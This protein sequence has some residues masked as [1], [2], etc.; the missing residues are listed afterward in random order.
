[1]IPSP[2]LAPPDAAPLS[3]VQPGFGSVHTFPATPNLLPFPSLAR[4]FL[5]FFSS[6][7]VNPQLSKLNL[8]PFDRSHVPSPG[9]SQQSPLPIHT[10]NPYL[11][12]IKQSPLPSSSSSTSSSSGG[13]GVDAT[14]GGQTVPNPRMNYASVQRLPSFS[15][16]GPSAV[17]QASPIQ[18]RPPFPSLVCSTSTRAVRY[19]PDCLHMLELLNHTSSDPL[20]LAGHR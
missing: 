3:P 14:R 12:L 19:Q 9:A 10:R 20:L 15:P 2:G 17:A 13:S 18:V 11:N 5:I 1:L 16:Q 4:S 6:F 8:P 7:V